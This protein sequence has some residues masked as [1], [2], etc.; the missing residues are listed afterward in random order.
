MDFPV[1]EKLQVRYADLDPYGHVNNAA[2]LDFFES[3]R[4][5]YLASLAGEA[6]LGP[7][8][9]GDLP[10][11]RYVIAEV[12]VRFKAPVYMEDDLHGAA[13]ICSIGDR[14]FVMDYELRTLRSGAGKDFG[15]GRKV[16]EGTSAQVFYD[17]ETHGILPRPG[18]FL[19]AVAGLEGRPEGSF[20]PEKR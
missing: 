5:A 4:V 14:S 7:M 2:Y 18:W 12:T 15:A 17:L 19:S 3:A 6:G 9:H 1:V 13:R 20:A 8:E 11:V 10:G 16:A